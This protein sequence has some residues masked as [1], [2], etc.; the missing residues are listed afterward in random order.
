[1]EEHRQRVFEVPK[2]SVGHKR[3][4]I[5]GKQRKLREVRPHI[6]AYIGHRIAFYEE[7][8]IER[9]QL[10]GHISHRSEYPD[11]NYPSPLSCGSV[12]PEWN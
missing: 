10:N 5:I 6:T 12:Y 2:R 9:C 1:V 8:H 4:E 3:E 7:G 11:W